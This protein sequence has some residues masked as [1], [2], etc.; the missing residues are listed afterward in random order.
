ME[1]NPGQDAYKRFFSKFSEATN[2]KIS[3]YFSNGS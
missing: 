2:I 1:K 3:D